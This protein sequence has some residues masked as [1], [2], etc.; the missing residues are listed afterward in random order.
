MSLP[1]RL[2]R[3][4]GLIA[5]RLSDLS[6]AQAADPLFWVLTSLSGLKYGRLTD[7]HAHWLAEKTDW[8]KAT[9]DALRRIG[10]GSLG[11]KR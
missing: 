8:R 10:E 1:T 11:G 4:S 7:E 3:E 5:E 2:L 6:F 9:R